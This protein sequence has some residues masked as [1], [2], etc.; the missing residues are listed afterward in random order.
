MSME[1][2]VINGIELSSFWREPDDERLGQWEA[3]AKTRDNRYFSA[4]DVGSEK[5]AR[6]LAL[7][8][9]EKHHAFLGADA[10]GKLRLIL[11]GSRGHDRLSSEHVTYAIRALAEIVLAAP[12]DPVS[13]CISQAAASERIMREL[14]APD[15]NC[16]ICQ[17]TGRSPSPNPDPSR[18]IAEM[19]NAC[20]CVVDKM[21]AGFRRRTR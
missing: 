10:R 5:K 13:N 6:V 4:F 9:A 16:P 3:T 8:R 17:G 15:P 11:E 1:T 20:R 19:P 2:A 14:A 12:S 21:L 7:E 18:F